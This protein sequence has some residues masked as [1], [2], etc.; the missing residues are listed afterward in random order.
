[1]LKRVTIDSIDSTSS[2]GTGSRCSDANRN[3]PR[4]VIRSV[5]WSSTRCVYSLNTS[6]RRARVECCSRNTVSGLKRCFGPPRRHW[7]SPPV[8]RPT[9]LS[10]ASSSGNAA[11]CRAADSA[12]ISGMP[13]PPSFVVVPVKYSCTNSFDRPTA[14]NACAAA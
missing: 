11:S 8:A 10:A 9:W 1:M 4:S 13:M 12:A 3:M 5:A 7:Y 14:S 2:S 6:Y